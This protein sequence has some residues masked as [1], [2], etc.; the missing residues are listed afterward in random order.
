MRR[1]QMDIFKWFKP[2]PP[3]TMLR[4]TKCGYELEYTDN[5]L[6][7]MAKRATPS[8]PCPFMDLCHICHTGFMVPI[9][10][11]KD[12]KIYLFEQIKPLVKNLDPK[13]AFIRIYSHED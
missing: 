1:S 4:C 2:P 5:E 3:D 6:R 12:G 10:Y 13:T 11:E 8:S 7:L 9:R